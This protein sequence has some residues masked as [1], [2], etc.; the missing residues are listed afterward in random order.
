[1]RIFCEDFL[2]KAH[3]KTQHSTSPTTILLIPLYSYTTIGGLFIVVLFCMYLD[4]YYSYIRCNIALCGVKNLIF[5]S[6]TG[7]LFSHP[8][9]ANHLER[10]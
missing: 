9:K 4:Y 10:S 8:P 7:F 1:M 3:I 5:N 2:T 6:K